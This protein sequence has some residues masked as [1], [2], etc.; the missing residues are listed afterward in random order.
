MGK[1]E[2]VGVWILLTL[3]KLTGQG[4]K[5]GDRKP[6]GF[7][8][9]QGHDQVGALDRMSHARDGVATDGL[10]SQERKCVQIRR[11]AAGSS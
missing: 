1:G 10:V 3:V 11:E 2:L 7:Q 8:A 5:K 9:E 4:D 6:L